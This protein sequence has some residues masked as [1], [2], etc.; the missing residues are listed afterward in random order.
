MDPC[1]FFLFPKIKYT[2]KGSGFVD[3]DTINLTQ[4]S[5]L[6][7]SPKQEVPSAVEEPLEC[8]Y[9]SRKDMLPA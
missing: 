2:L 8:V 6:S 9:P 5:N 3:V 4:C 1:D 7:R